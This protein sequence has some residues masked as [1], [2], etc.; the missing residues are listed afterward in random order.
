MDKLPWRT[1]TTP[2]PEAS[3]CSGNSLM[4]PSSCSSPPRHDRDR[5]RPLGSHDHGDRYGGFF[6]MVMTMLI[7]FA[8]SMI[9]LASSCAWLRPW[10]SL[11]GKRRGDRV[12]SRNTRQYR[13]HRCR[14]HPLL[15][16][17]AILTGILVFVVC[18]HDRALLACA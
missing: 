8:E 15:L 7:L 5:H 10:P 1:D 18:G 3:N 17:L 6:I 12:I 11:S 13:D 2:I 14:Q 9:F 4:T 16:L